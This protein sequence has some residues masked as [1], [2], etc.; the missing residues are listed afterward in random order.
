MAALFKFFR[1]TVGSLVIWKQNKRLYA[2]YIELL[3]GNKD[4]KYNKY[5]SNKYISII[6]SNWSNMSL[7]N[8]YIYIFNLTR[9]ILFGGEKK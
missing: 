2:Y 1:R 8:I 9:I 6:K 3:R 7:Q 5:I 4:F